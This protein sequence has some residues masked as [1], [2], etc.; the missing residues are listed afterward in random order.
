MVN[1]L[2]DIGSNTIRLVVYDGYKEIENYADYAGLISYVSNG[3]ISPVGIGKI[4]KALLG[5]KKRAEALGA[6]S[7]Y[8]FATAS[9]RDITD[10]EGLVSFVKDATGIK[11]EIITGESEAYYDYLGLKKINGIDNGAAFDLGGGSCQVMV[12][13]KGK[14]EGAVSLPLGGLKLH[15]EFVKGNIPSMAEREQISEYAK[16]NVDCFKPFINCGFSHLYAMGGSVFAL[17]SLAKVY[18]GEDYRLDSETLKQLC[19][20]SEEQI[21]SVVSKRLKSVIPAAIVMV[22]LLAASGAEEILITPAGV[23]DGILFSRLSEPK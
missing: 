11:I 19:T 7:I 16:S 8:A 10:K 13:R 21:C 1:A 23:R 3:E 15:S 12:F 17:D 6:E 9:L 20:L 18:I 4:I 14:V 5:M 22:E 2:I